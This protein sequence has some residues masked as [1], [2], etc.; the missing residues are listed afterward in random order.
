MAHGIIPSVLAFSGVPNIVYD[1]PVK[2]LKTVKRIKLVL[3]LII[4]FHYGTLAWFRIIFISRLGVVFIPNI[5]AIGL[6][7]RSLGRG[8]RKFSVVGISCKSLENIN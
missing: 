7:Y 6:V 1:L 5:H 2:V 4:A 8:G 3:W